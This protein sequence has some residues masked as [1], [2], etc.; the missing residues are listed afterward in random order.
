MDKRKIFFFL[1]ILALYILPLTAQSV[2][3]L[4]DG[5]ENQSEAFISARYTANLFRHFSV[6]KIIIRQI[7]TYR[8]LM[9]D[10]PDYLCV[11]SDEGPTRI[12]ELLLRD[13]ANRQRPVIWLNMN[14][15]QLLEIDESRY[16]ITLKNRVEHRGWKIYYKGQ[17]YNKEDRWLNLMDISPKKSVKIHSYI[18]SPDGHRYPYIL[19]TKNLWY[20]SD[21]PYSYADEGGRYLILADLL[22]DILG[23]QPKGNSFAMVRIEDV[24]SYTKP[25][26]IKKIADFFD[27]RNV[28]F[29]ISLVPIYR[30]SETQKDVYLRDVPMLVEA[31]KYAVSK[32]ASIVMHGVTHQYK[33]T[34]TDDF[35]FWDSISHKP[36]T[37]VS[38]EWIRH[39]MKQGIK[40]LLFNDL[41]PLGWETPHYSA[42]QINYKIFGEYFNV[43]FER[44]MV[45][46]VAGT[47]QILPFPIVLEGSGVT[48]V[49]ENM[50][51]VRYNNPDS[52]AILKNARKLRS[53]RDGMASFYFHPF[54]PIEHLKKI[55]DGMLE[56]GWDFISLKEFP[57]AA[58][59]DSFRITSTTG[60]HS[61]SLINQYYRDR[62]VDDKGKIKKET[63][64]KK[65]ETRWV[66]EEKKLSDGQI[67]IMEALDV[68]PDTSKARFYKTG[69]RLDR[70]G[71]EPVVFERA[72]VLGLNNLSEADL[73]CQKSYESVLKIFGFSPV[74]LY[75]G[76]EEKFSIEG[77]HLIVVPNLVALELMEIEM[78]MILDFVERGGILITDGKSR[79]TEKL[80]V[81]FSQTPIFVSKIK[82][83]TLAVEPI[84]WKQS[85]PVFTVIGDDMTVL[86]QDQESQV[87]VAVTIPFGLGKALIL[88]A[89]FDPYTPY[90]ISHYP[91]FPF[92]LKNQ[93]GV[94][95]HF[96]SRTL[97]FYFD[98]GLRQNTSWENLVYQWKQSG[99]KIVY[100]AAW[101]FYLNY[102]FD[103]NY[104]INLCHQ[105]GIGVYAWFEFPQVSHTF[106]TAHPEW[107]EKNVSGKDARNG[108]RMQMNLQNEDCLEA[109]T[110]FLKNVL[111]EYDWDGINFAE[112][113]YDTN[114]GLSDPLQFAPMN[115]EVRRK[116]EKK[117][118]IDPILLFDRLSP[119]YWKK[120][121]LLMNKFLVYRTDLIKA[122]HRHFIRE[123]RS[124]QRSKKKEMEIIVTVLDSLNHP[125]IIE[126]CGV[127]IL[128]IIDMMADYSFTLQVEDPTRSWIDLPSRYQLF[129]E[130]YLPRIK[131]PKRLM[132]DIN[133]VKR[134]DFKK[135]HLPSPWAV[136]TE[137]ATTFYYAGLPSNRV[138]I[139]SEYTVN[140]IDM[141]MLSFA[142]GSSHTVSAENDG[143]RIN[144]P[145]SMELILEKGKNI[146]PVMD[147]ERWPFFQDNTVSIPSGD[148]TL[149]FKRVGRYRQGP[150]SV[151]RMLFNGHISNLTI[152]E[153]LLS[154]RFS[155]VNPV[156]LSFDQHLKSI[157]IDS[158]EIIL[159]ETVRNLVLSA[160]NHRVE[161]FTH[162]QL[163]DN[164]GLI[165]FVTSSIFYVFGLLAVGSLIILYIY[166]RSK[167]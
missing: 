96:R 159:D 127:D 117:E 109:A 7:D 62:V 38:A 55:V 86:C 89:P 52:E 72:L 70:K 22:F 113:C 32:G 20:V 24:N 54:V 91:Y 153:N 84:S 141:S 123:I 104:F 147:G 130:K 128:D 80:N 156:I 71:S 64:I 94:G 166:S 74:I 2:L 115:R 111:M 37:S 132:F 33:G 9:D 11:I 6:D 121:Q 3:I 125:E 82:D 49:P 8:T 137:L 136:G 50:G 46:D 120:D 14:V 164:I 67:F 110:S 27:E 165:G 148:H 42:S 135:T 41:Y 31:L 142:V 90:G 144:S 139:Y 1:T 45:A 30:S 5:K 51:F 68:L 167:K 56:M 103:Y 17:Q 75:L 53:I 102:Q 87:P 19:Q 85:V 88:S 23:E 157:R 66:E 143:F 29:Q 25:H 18:E 133:V 97:E 107:R 149:S 140:P 36:L 105:N 73:N 131:D 35:E 21:S 16:G 69:K 76:S 116:F 155:S 34:T 61:I 163:P 158:K 146:M 101:H 114:K 15:N 47:Q 65:R 57:C 83:L 26:S 77:Y 129:T 122:L 98:P 43:F 112:L 40:E 58:G 145:R 160:G 100:L 4:Y 151:P 48:L 10:Q 134:P 119:F 39:R 13:L 108:W 44:M 138:G 28:P 150:L 59:D 12:P 93:L 63:L 60:R 106:W 79:L 161:M 78:N 92:Y 99:V 154:F 162:N 81:R 152:A 118:G 126:E 95:F 124:V